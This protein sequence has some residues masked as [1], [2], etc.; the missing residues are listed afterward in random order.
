MTSR[1]GYAHCNSRSGGDM[2]EPMANSDRKSGNPGRQDENSRQSGA[3][4]SPKRK[5][6]QSGTAADEGT[7]IG[8]S[9]GQDRASPRD[10]HERVDRGSTPDRSG[11]TADIERGAQS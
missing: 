9:Q 10:R 7:G 4:G 11:G 3:Q 1:R 8:S 5:G 6:G 2:E